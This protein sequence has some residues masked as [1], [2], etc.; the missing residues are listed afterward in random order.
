MTNKNDPWENGELG[1]D[2]EHAQ[3]SPLSDDAFDAATGLKPVS[4][5]LEED[6]IEC[7]KFFAQ[8]EGLGYQPLIR[9]LLD[10][11]LKS[12]VRAYKK[13]Q[14]VKINEAEL[15]ARYAKCG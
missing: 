9:R 12:E 6:M 8:M 1:Q 7:L 13:Y 11:W 3:V 15:P 2:M 10:R 14:K 5:R 4:I